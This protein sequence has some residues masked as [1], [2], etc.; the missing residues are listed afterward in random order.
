MET[1]NKTIVCIG[2]GPSGLVTAKY[3]KE[4]G[5]RVKVLEAEDELGGT[6]KWRTYDHGELVSSRQLTG[7]LA[8]EDCGDSSLSLTPVKPL[9]IFGYRTITTTPNALQKITC[10]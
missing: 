10:C 5:F 9:A 6:F 3:A 4:L 7:R 1:A 2:A 8:P